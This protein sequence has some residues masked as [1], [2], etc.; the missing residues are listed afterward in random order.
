[1]MSFTAVLELATLVAYIV[2]ILGGKQKREG[3]WKVLASM[4]LLIGVVQCASMAIV[5]RYTLK[6]KAIFANSDKAYLF[7]NDERFFVGW[8]LDKS[9]ILCTVS[10]SIAI[11]SAAS[12]SL[13]AFV[14]P[15]EDGYELIPSERYGR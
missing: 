15:P 12:I 14:F 10:W 7:D 1:M 5:V 6:R 2:V 11:L 9:W 4:L 13:S 3:G 8:K